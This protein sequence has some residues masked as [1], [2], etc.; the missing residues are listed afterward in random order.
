M[1]G[2]GLSWDVN[3]DDDGTQGLHTWEGAP[4]ACLYN[5]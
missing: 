5:K 4:C 2:V 3:Y 1:A